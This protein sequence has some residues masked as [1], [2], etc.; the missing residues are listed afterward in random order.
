MS[1]SIDQSC[2]NPRENEDLF[3]RLLTTLNTWWLT[4]TYPF[5]S[6]GQGVKFHYA[7]EISRKVATRISLG[8]QIEIGRHAW[9]TCGAEGPH[10]QKIL[11]GDNCRIG[12]CCTIS[13]KNSIQLE[14]GVA[15]APDVL[16]QDHAHA[17][18][19]VSRPVRMQG[20]TSGGKIRI[21]EGCRIGRGAAILSGRGEL[22]I[23]KNSVVAPDAVVMTSFPPNSV[24][25]GNPARAM[26]LPGDAKHF[27]AKDAA[28]RAR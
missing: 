9:I 5:A 4:A 15:L 25:S 20:P 27:V 23:G 10:Q 2:E 26:P 22:V 7:S 1:R 3:S 13:S 21:G 16:I 28:G 8:N 17:Y 6:T 14:Q 12:P 11:I 19:D 18:E 24:I